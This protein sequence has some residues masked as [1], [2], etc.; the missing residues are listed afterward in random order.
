MGA[1]PNV[2]LNVPSRA[3]NVLLIRQALSG[4]AE[5]V[6]LDPVT[7]GDISTAV[8]EAANNV[9]LHAYEGAEGPLEVELAGVEGGLDVLVRDRGCGIS[10]S[11]QSGESRSDGIGLPVIRALSSHVEFRNRR[12][13]GTE[14]AMHFELDQVPGLGAQS[15]LE[16]TS[17]PEQAVAGSQEIVLGVAP[18]AVARSVV[19]RVLATLAARAYFTTDRISDAQLL[20]DTL[21]AGLDGAAGDG[22]LTL[23]FDVE[24]RKLELRIGPLSSGRAS[25]LFSA[26]S[27]NG[28]GSILDRLSD[29][30]S[31]SESGSH[32]LLD[33]RI[34]QRN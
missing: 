12:A 22:R 2:R 11:V 29:G 19:P 9:V 15:R 8:T 30:H 24:P 13:G 4:L 32:E 14:V 17:G 31:V 10:P 23:A 7:L 34:A 21:V 25:E 28:L 1:A 16:R 5:S 6:G 27:S 20:A 3:E 26:G 18:T 33:L